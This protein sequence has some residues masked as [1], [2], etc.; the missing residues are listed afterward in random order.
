MINTKLLVPSGASDQASGGDRS[1]AEI[2]ERAMTI[3]QWA[4]LNP[5]ERSQ[6][7]VENRLRRV[8]EVLRRIGVGSDECDF[9]QRHAPDIHPAGVFTQTELEDPNFE[10]N[11][12]PTTESA[13]YLDTIGGGP[14][15]IALDEANNRLYVTT[16]F[17]NSVEVIELGTGTTSA[18]HTLHNPEDA[19]IVDGRPCRRPCSTSVPIRSSAS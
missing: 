16:R 18:V 12:D 4:G 15:G 11:F 2:L 6:S 7:A 10:A 17:N 8:A 13:D 5:V 3:I 1:G 19:S 9:L 14:S